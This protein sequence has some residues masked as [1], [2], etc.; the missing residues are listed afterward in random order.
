MEPKELPC[1]MCIEAFLDYKKVK[2]THIYV[3]PVCPFVGMEYIDNQ[4]LLDLTE[5][6][7]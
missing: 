3:C 2:N 6:L 5:Y 7:K 4:N 1:P